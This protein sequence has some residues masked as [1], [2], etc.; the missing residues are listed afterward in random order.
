MDVL[1]KQRRASLFIHTRAR[2]NRCAF[3]MTRNALGGSFDGIE[4]GSVLVSHFG[5]GLVGHFAGNC[6]AK[7]VD[8]EARIHRLHRPNTQCAKPLVVSSRGKRGGER[9][10]DALERGAYSQRGS[11]L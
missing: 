2:H 10:G 3:D 7:A 8:S 4:G 9:R 1:E 11:L 6:C 5:L